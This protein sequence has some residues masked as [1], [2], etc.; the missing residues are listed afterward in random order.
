LLL[1]NVLAGSVG[2]FLL[3]YYLTY[4]TVKASLGWVGGGMSFLTFLDIVMRSTTISVMGVAPTGR[5]GY[6]GYVSTFLEVL[7]FAAGGLVVWGY[8]RSEMYC[9]RCSWRL[10]L[11]GRQ[12]RYTQRQEDLLVMIADVQSA[13]KQG[14]VSGAILRHTAT[15][16]FARYPAS[17]I[18]SV[19]SVYACGHC[20]RHT[21]MSFVERPSGE[22][23]LPALGSTTTAY[24]DSPVEISK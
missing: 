9:D 16:S 2:T 8:L 20:G 22:D 10:K 6:F 5:L 14:D 18:R 12:V 4:L 23:W 24:S 17:S 21:A 19:C 15:G 7:G 11:K 1:P 13:L 3:I